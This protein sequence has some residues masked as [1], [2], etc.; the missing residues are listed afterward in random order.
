MRL[1]MSIHMNSHVCQTFLI[2]FIFIVFY[3]FYT[4]HT[5]YRVRAIATQSFN[6]TT[7]NC[8]I[9]KSHFNF[10]RHVFFAVARHV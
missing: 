3:Q 10:Y 7:K 5:T 1:Q 8:S 2:L 4:R 9:G 6:E